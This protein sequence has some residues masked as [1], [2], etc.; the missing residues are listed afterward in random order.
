[1]GRLI[2]AADDRPGAEPVAVI[3]DSLWRSRF[4]GDPNVIGRM[5]HVDSQAYRVAGVMPREFS[6][7][8]GNDFPGQYQFASLR[9]TDVWVPAALTPKQQSDPEFDGMD[10]A[11]GRL[12]PGVT[13]AQAQAELSATE[14]HLNAA[15][16]EGWTDLEVLLAPFLET[17][18]GPVRPLLRLLTGAVCLILLMACGNLASLLLARAANRTHELGVRAALGAGRSSPCRSPIFLNCKERCCGFPFS[19]ENCLSAL[20][21]MC[22]CSAW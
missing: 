11:I 14:K 8:H 16:P 12:R 4:G 22:G 17:A 9:R 15:H 18:M 21:R 1:M 10:A 6:Y 3:S 5:I 7:P 2:D 19:N 13:L 20:L